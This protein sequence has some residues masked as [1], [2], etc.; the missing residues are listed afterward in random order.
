MSSRYINVCVC[1]RVPQAGAQGA[2]GAESARPTIT[3]PGASR[4]A[5]PDDRPSSAEQNDRDSDS[6]KS[7]SKEVKSSE[8]AKGGKGGKGSGGGG[9]WL[10]GILTKLS[11]RAP[12]QMILP[13][14]TN[15]TIVWDEERKR[16]RDTAAPESEAAALP[17]PPPTALPALAQLSTSTPLQSPA[18]GGAPPAVPVSNIFKMQK[19]RHIKKSYVDVLNPGG[20]RTSSAP[21][22]AHPAPPAPPAAPV[23][24]PT[25]YFVPAPAPAQ[26]GIYDPTL[27]A[28][29]NDD[30]RSGI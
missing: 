23:P 9:G 15:P 17:P 27:L 21:L 6:P 30:Y 3:M 20:A 28:A 5:P 29:T 18:A 11:R 1:L 7:T 22:A 2:E 25:D 10:G 12:N 14:D 4:S 16:W 24:P 19:G 13:D 8:G 26:G